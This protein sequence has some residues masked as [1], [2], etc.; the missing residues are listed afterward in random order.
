MKLT[1][2]NQTDVSISIIVNE[3][4]IDIEPL[5]SKSI[6]TE[7]DSI[8]VKKKNNNYKKF[9]IRNLGVSNYEY[10]EASYFDYLKTQVYLPS[11]CSKTSFEINVKDFCNNK[12][13]N[14]R[15]FDVKGIS[16]ENVKYLYNDKK[17]HKKIKRSTFLT[18]FLR[19]GI[20]FTL[21]F[22]CLIGSM[23]GQEVED[24]G[25]AIALLAVVSLCTGGLSTYRLIEIIKVLKKIE[26][27]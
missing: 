14:L 16:N 26:K 11:N 6:E 15:C 9:S 22:L 2:K 24:D 1:I 5:K 18:L 17:Q 10:F 27:K 8:I 12:F 7:Q 21:S 20:W 25:I 23:F 19:Y 13:L 4:T 3:S